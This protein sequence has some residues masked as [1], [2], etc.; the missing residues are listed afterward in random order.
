MPLAV[1]IRQET[2]SPSAANPSPA[3][4]DPMTLLGCF[5]DILALW[6]TVFPQART[7]LRALR[8]AVGGLLCLGRHTLSRIIWTNGDQHKDWRADYFLFSRCKWDLAALFAPILQ[9]ALAYCPGRYIGVA[10]DDTGL[11]KT[12]LRIQQALVQRDPLSPK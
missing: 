9:R 12:G 8:Q 10:M 4:R 7:F 6:A 1:P 3:P 2:G 11:H 5:L